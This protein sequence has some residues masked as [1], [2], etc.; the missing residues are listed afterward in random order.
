MKLNQIFERRIDRSI[1]TV[2]KADDREHIKQEVEEYVITR[3]VARKIRDFFAAYND[4]QGANGVWISGFFGSG[5]SHL[6]KILSYVMENRENEGEQLG[7]VFADKIVEDDLLRADVLQATRIPSESILFNIDQ[8]AQITSK[9]EEDAILTVFYKVLND[10]LGYFG[11]Q[12]HVADFERWVTSEGKYDAFVAKF[13]TVA[14]EPWESGRRK[15]FSPK[16][17]E[18]IDVALNDLMG[19]A[20]E[21][22]GN[23]IDTLRKDHAISIEDLCIR[24]N[25]YIQTKSK[26][27]RLNFFV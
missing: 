4:Y 12:K 1:E 5:K 13:A 11:G 18:A 6:L 3:E 16:I 27:F 7:K 9:Q 24:V 20:T 26:G 21:G 17:K 14:G 22:Y 2:I 19:V 15:Y 23:I 8:Q 10:H 25:E